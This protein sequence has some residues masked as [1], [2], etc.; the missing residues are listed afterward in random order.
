VQAGTIASN[1]AGAAIA[2][3]KTTAGTTILSGTNSYSGATTITAGTLQLGTGGGAGSLTNS[4]IVINAGATLDVNRSGSVSFSRAI[5]GAG[6]FVKDG[7]GSLMLSACTSSG[8]L[9]VNSGSLSYSGTSTLPLGNYTV[10]GGTLSLG[11]RTQSIGT[12]RIVA[13]GTI[14]GG[15]LTSNA[16]YDVRG[17]TIATVLAGGATIDLNKTGPD[18]AIVSS[19][20][21]FG[22]LTTVSAGTLQLGA[23]ATVG[24]VAGNINIDAAGTLNYYRSNN[25]TFA[26]KLSGTGTLM[27]TGAGTLT[28]TG[29]NSFSGNVVLGGGTLDYS[30][31]AT[32]PAGNYA[33]STGTLN[34]GTLSQSIAGLQITGGTIAGAGTL[35][36]AAT[37]DV[38]GGV[39][40]AALAGTAGLTKTGSG[41]ALLENDNAYTGPTLI[42][43]GV[44]A[45]SEFGQL[46]HS[47]TIDN[48]AA[49]LISAGDHAANN[50][51]GSG[52]TMVD[53][54]ST[55]AAASIVQDSLV[56]GGDHSALLATASAGVAWTPTAV[57]EPN[58]WALLASLAGAFLAVR[59]RRK[60]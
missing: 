18:T 29:V 5:S 9:V 58:T 1:L 13:G 11:T 56:I 34:I 26:G 4:S 54:N 40:D 22:G 59:T 31:N 50:I 3:N 30:G 25:A 20:C 48:R 8:D 23:G 42:T 7:T 27:K 43:D 35:T 28:M 44:L 45:L 52:T 6:A 16:D 47:S 39:I 51:V 49:L 10:N 60:M 32:L 38:Q 46:A 21:S 37:F 33:V 14:T 53:L 19:D 2:L 57:P 15:T 17:G 55:L 12:L 41:A 24:S 36:S